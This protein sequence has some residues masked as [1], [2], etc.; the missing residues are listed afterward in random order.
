MGTYVRPVTNSSPAAIAVIGQA[1]PTLFGNRMV[2]HTGEIVNVQGTS[3]PPYGA[4]FT[5]WIDGSLLGLDLRR[6]DVAANGQ[7]TALELG[8]WDSGSQTIG[9]IAVLAT[10]GIDQLPAFPAAVAASCRRPGSPPTRRCRSMRH[11][12][13]GPTTVA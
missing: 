1:H 5:S 7:L 13:P 2:A 11:A 4:D 3:D 9:K 10:Q 6:T 12:S 8:E